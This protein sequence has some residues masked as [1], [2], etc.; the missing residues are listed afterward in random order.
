MTKLELA[1]AIY[2]ELYQLNTMAP[3]HPL[4]REVVKM[5][6]QSKTTLL[7]QYEQAQ[8]AAASVGRTVI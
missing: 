2:T 7:V 6:R 4:P 8:H 1:R 3:S 5:S